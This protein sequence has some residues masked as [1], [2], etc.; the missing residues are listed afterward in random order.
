MQLF[1]VAVC[2][3][4]SGNVQALLQGG[5]APVLNC[6]QQHLR[7]FFVVDEKDYTTILIQR[8]LCLF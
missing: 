5:T 6:F 1:L 7:N 8:F 4:A 2:L 3:L